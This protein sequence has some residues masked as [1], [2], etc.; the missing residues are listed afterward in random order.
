MV[1]RYHDINKTNRKLC[2]PSFWDIN[3]SNEFSA[4]GKPK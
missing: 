3:W 2:P 1:L 4:N